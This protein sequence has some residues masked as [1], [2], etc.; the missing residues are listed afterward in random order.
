VKKVTLSVFAFSLILFA[1]IRRSPARQVEPLITG[2]GMSVVTLNMA[3]STEIDGIL[4]EFNG[5][6]ALRD[7]D[8][9]MLQEVKQDDGARQ[10]AAEMLAA[11]LG[12]H[13]V[14]SPATTGVTDQGLAILSRYPLRDVQVR[15]LKKFDLRYRSRTRIALGATADSPWGPVRIFNAHLDTRLNTMQRLDQLQPV[16]QASNQFQGPLIIGGDFNSN[17]FYW[18]EH[19]LPLPTWRSQAH[20]VQDFMVRNGFHTSIPAGETTFDYLGMHLDWIWLR[21][22]HSSVSR[23]YPLDFSDHH[24]V[25]SRVEFPKA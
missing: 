25:W 21:G 17:R 4:R 7:A 14:Y 15:P 10:C 1:V 23:I 18:V 5:I 12:L 8:I 13:V 6:N 11:K 19:V 9:L 2:P 20:G 24:A 22:L 3:K 16:L